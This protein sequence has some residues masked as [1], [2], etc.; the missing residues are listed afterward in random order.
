MKKENFKLKKVKLIPTGGLECEYIESTLTGGATQ[1]QTHTVKN[2]VVPHPDL[3]SSLKDFTNTVIEKNGLNPIEGIREHS[4]LQ[5]AER[6][7]LNKI[8]NVLD[9]IAEQVQEG[10]EV[11]GLHIKKDGKAIVINAKW[12]T[13]NG[14]KIAMNT[15]VLAV[16]QEDEKEGSFHN[17]V[18]DLEMEVFQYLVHGK[19]AQLTIDD[20]INMIEQNQDA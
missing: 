9:G 4:G 17:M 10:T 15:P 16:D 8:A 6:N 20:E 13:Q 11:Y 14:Q 12:K 2:T 5:A 7:A 19:K 18:Q 1:T 3:V